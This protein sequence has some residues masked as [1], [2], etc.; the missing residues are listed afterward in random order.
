MT[1][2]TAE[3][4]AWVVKYIVSSTFLA[5]ALFTGIATAGGM[6]DNSNKAKMD[7]AT[8]D[9][10]YGEYLS[11]D[12]TSCHSLYVDR[13]RI[14][15]LAGLP[16]DFLNQT[17]RSYRAGERDNQAMTTV[18]KSLSDDDIVSVAAWLSSLEKKEN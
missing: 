15:A 16:E 11:N 8:I 5:V 7:K 3:I 6:D 14:I 17:L 10:E 9:L 2:R 1:H 13:D 12:C 4:P 18:A